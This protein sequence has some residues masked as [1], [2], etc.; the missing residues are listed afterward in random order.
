MNLISMVQRSFHPLSAFFRHGSLTWEM[1]KRDVQGR[2]R[3]ASLGIAW[4]LISPFLMLLVY[5]L[6]FGSIM[7][8]KW[9]QADGETSDFALIIF[10][11]LIIHGFFA[12]CFVRS[13]NLVVGNQNFV[14]KII[15]PLE[16]LP[17]PLIFSALFHAGMNF[18][19][20]VM[21]H[22]C[23][24]GPVPIT[25][26]LLPVVML[27]LAILMVGLSWFIAATSVY[28]RDIGQLTTPIATAMLFLSSAIVPVELAPMRF[29]FLFKL[30]PITLIIDQARNVALWGRWPDWDSLALYSVIAV[31]VA[32]AGLVFFQFTRRGFAD[33][34]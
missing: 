11:G 16:I 33:V 23:V 19:V 15:F 34:L 10:V 2:Y 6:A 18:L 31:L 5:T 17:W 26:W 20:F 7:K 3:G 1:A 9:P 4:S 14:K 28:F 25:I 13:A 32:A 29:Q 22:W 27:P 30:N 12:E 8:A 24:N 21:F